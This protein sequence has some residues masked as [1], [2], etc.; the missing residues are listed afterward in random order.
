MEWY[1]IVEFNVPLDTHFGGPWAV[2]CISHS[3]MESQRHNNPQSPTPLTRVA[4][5]YNDP[6]GME[7]AANPHYSGGS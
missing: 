7:L 1:G 2:M 3:V 4:F 6:K 5:V